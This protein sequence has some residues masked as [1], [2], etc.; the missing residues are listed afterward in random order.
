[1]AIDK[2]VLTVVCRQSSGI[3]HNL[4]SLQTGVVKDPHTGNLIP[5]FE[6]LCTR[7][8]AKWDE[9]DQETRARRPGGRRR[10]KEAVPASSLSS[11]PGPI[12]ASGQVEHEEEL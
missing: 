3:A 10:A 2:T 5:S 8:G 4:A 7:C 11:P 1:M 6:I 9:L 12:A